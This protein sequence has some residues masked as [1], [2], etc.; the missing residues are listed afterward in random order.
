MTWKKV[1]PAG[2]VAENAVA[3]QDVD[4]TKIA[5]VRSGDDDLLS[6]QLWTEPG[7]GVEPDAERL[8]TCCINK[9]EIAP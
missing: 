2:E 6:A 4:G 9:A 1:C 5:V 3:E 8:E 7:I